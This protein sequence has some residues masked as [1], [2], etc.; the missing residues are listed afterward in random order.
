ML[1]PSGFIGRLV[2]AFQSSPGATVELSAGGTVRAR[3]L[4][5]V[6]GQVWRLAIGG[7][8]VEA[9]VTVPLRQG[10]VFLA[11][12]EHTANE[13]IL[14]RILSPRGGTPLERIT[15]AAG[16]P[17]DA[18]AQ[19]IITH[20]VHAQRS[21][22]PQY[23]AR[24]YRLARR[25]GVTDRRGARL[26]AAVGGKGLS[27]ESAAAFRALLDEVDLPD[28]LY[29][30][31]GRNRDGGG[32]GGNSGRDG[33]NRGGFGGGGRD[34]RDRRDRRGGHPDEGGP[35]EGDRDAARQLSEIV[36]SREAT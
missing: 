30:D 5:R 24:L 1:E 25:L 27:P 20:L 31:T 36:R 28:N 22:D 11:R 13:I 2:G 12:V 9:R 15:S 8:V 18:L 33:G 4:S 7:R 21:L 14:R 3:V 26:A 10:Q 34:G 23:I 32:R 6:S 19:G 16:V 29:D 17:N 35:D